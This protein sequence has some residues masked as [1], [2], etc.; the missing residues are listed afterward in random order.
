MTD[1]LRITKET[2]TKESIEEIPE[3]V[4]KEAE[5]QEIRDNWEW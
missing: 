4:D 2:S 1:F 3:L 5:Y